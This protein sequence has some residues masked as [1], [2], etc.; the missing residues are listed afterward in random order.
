M[1]V[2]NEKQVSPDW[3]E[4]ERDYANQT[5]AKLIYL[6]CGQYVHY[7]KSDL[8]SIEIRNFFCITIVSFLEER[9]PI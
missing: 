8:I 1:F 4:Y 5:N 2:S 7:Y 9:Q 6:N 3:L